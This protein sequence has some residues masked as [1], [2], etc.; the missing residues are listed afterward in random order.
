MNSSIKTHNIVL[1]RYIK[2]LFL[3]YFSSVWKG[4][5]LGQLLSLLLCTMAVLCQLLV[6][7]YGAKIPTGELLHN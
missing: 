2:V 5:L 6:D 1:E 4:L 3:L 7:T